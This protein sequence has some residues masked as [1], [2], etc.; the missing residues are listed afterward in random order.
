MAYSEKKLEDI[1]EE[2]GA[3]GFCGSDVRGGGGGGR[4]QGVSGSR[5]D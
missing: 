1:L 2:I 3:V 5:R 4:R